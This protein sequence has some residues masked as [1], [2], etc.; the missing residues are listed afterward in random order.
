[1]ATL[2]AIL[3]M[4]CPRC[5]KGGVFRGFLLTRRDCPVCRLVFE[6][7]PGYFVG[8]MY[9]SYA[10]G[11]FGTAPVWFTMLITGQSLAAILIVATLLVVGLAP[12]FFHYSRILWL[13]WD[14]HFNSET[15]AN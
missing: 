3:L 13:Y 15:F 4:R 11:V 2:A 9:A 8:A 6:R 5:R 12:V 14:Y 1:M 7:E 10:L